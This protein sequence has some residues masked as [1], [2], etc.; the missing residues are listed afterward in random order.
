MPRFCAL[1][2]L[3]FCNTI[4]YSQTCTNTFTGTVIDLHDNSLLAGATV[5]L[6]GSETAVQTDIN[7]EFTFNNLCNSTYS[8]QVSHP[9]CATKGY[10]VL[11]D[12]DTNKTFKLEHHLEELNQVIIEGN[13]FASKSISFNNHLIKLL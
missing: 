12:G 8:F 13:A 2:L 9:F 11:I 3:L 6:A 7:G 5:I 4:V 10:T 1:L